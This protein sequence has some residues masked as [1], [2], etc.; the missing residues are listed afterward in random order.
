MIF[1]LLLLLLLSLSFGGTAWRRKDKKDAI[2]LLLLFP[3]LLQAFPI[4]FLISEHKKR[5][6]GLRGNNGRKKPEESCLGK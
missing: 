6:R 1:L 2:L 4:C 3:L 5:N